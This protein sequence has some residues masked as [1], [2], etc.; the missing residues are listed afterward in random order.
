[1]IIIILSPFEWHICYSILSVTNF[2]CVWLFDYNILLCMFLVY[3]IIFFLGLE[4]E[5]GPSKSISSIFD[6]QDGIPNFE[7]PIVTIITIQVV[8]LSS[9]TWNIKILLFYY[10]VEIVYYILSN[11]SIT[12]LWIRI[13][14]KKTVMYIDYHLIQQSR[15]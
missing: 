3:Y 1:M 12:A 6:E 5:I 10:T 15:W 11:S 9:L 2:I 8:P 7:E 13:I 14:K 4:N